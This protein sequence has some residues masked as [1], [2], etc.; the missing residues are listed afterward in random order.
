M[1]PLPSA[2]V[3]GFF[4]LPVNAALA[5][6]P[7]GVVRVRF[8]EIRQSAPPGSFKMDAALGETLVELPLAK[9]VAGMNPKWLA[10]RPDQKKVEV[11]ADIPG[12]FATKEQKAEKPAPVP[13]PE[14]TLDA[15][16][17]EFAAPPPVECLT[18]KLSTVFEGWPETVRTELTQCK[19]NDCSAAIPLDRL[20]WAIKSGRVVFQWGDVRQWLEGKPPGTTTLR[21]T[22][23][24]FPLKVIV[25]QFMAR[26]K[27]SVAR[28]KIS[29]PDS[30]PN[31]FP[32]PGA[33]AAPASAPAPAPVP[34]PVKPIAAP[35]AVAAAVAPAAP[36]ERSPHEIVKEINGLPGVA[37]SVIAMSDGLLVAGSLPAPIKSE[38]MAAFLP[39]LFGRLASYS[40]EI[41]LGQ[42][43]SLTM[44]AGPAHFAIF[45]TGAAYLAVLGKAGEP[46]PDTQLQRIATELARRGP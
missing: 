27:L 44:Q 21:E 5:Q 8:A 11:P 26:R 6:L 39:Q 24:E 14:P 32:V 23:V 3:K 9:V 22:L 46:L 4:P 18:V 41:Q 28:P 17:A 35:P 31:L 2:S 20:E 10:R 15:M 34:E 12:A 30:I 19:L 40:N 45:K 13:S 25:P 37:G 1:A 16:A 29:I 7:T 42:I 33:A 43:Q 36:K 38:T